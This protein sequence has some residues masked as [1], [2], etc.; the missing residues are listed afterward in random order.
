MLALVVG[1]NMHA[2]GVQGLDREPETSPSNAIAGAMAGI[3]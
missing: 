3:V 2:L 1:A